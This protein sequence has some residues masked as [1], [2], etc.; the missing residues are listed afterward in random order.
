MVLVQF[1][2]LLTLCFV[3]VR[4]VCARRFRERPY[5]KDT[6]A[7]RAAL[8]SS[9]DVTLEGDFC[10]S[11]CFLAS[12]VRELCYEGFL[13][14]SCELGGGTGLFVLLP[15][16]T[17]SGAFCASATCVPRKLRRRSVLRG[18]TLSMEEASTR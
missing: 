8:K 2:M 10:W 18:Y 5:L 13:P 9:I 17:R 16:F 15:C 3:I 6:A 12:F 7:F 4:L 11:L 14:I 1:V